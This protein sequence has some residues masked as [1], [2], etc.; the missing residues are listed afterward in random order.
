MRD[1]NASALF[2]FI[3]HVVIRFATAECD[4]YSRNVKS[5]IAGMHRTPNSG[6]ERRFELVQVEEASPGNGVRSG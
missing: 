4:K 5:S 1:Y 3:I 2:V 6:R